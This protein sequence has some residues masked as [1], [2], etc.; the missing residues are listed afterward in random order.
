MADWSSLDDAGRDAVVRRRGVAGLGELREAA[1]QTGVRCLACDSGLR[2][3]A[4]D[5]AGLLPG[6]EVSGIATLL[7]SVAGGQ[8]LAF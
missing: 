1:L 3:E 2:A 6:V 4:I 5:A 8:L 7:E